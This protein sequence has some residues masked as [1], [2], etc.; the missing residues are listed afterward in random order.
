MKSRILA[1]TVL[2][3][4]FVPV[5]SVMAGS[6]GEAATSEKPVVT[7]HSW[8]VSGRESDVS[9][10][11]FQELEKRLDIEIDLVAMINTDN[12]NKLSTMLA[13]NELYDSMSMTRAF[14]AQYGPQGAFVD[15]TTTFD[16]APNL[17]RHFS[18]EADPWIYTRKELYF[19]PGSPMPYLAWGWAWNK[20][21]AD[22]LGI[23]PPKTMD[24]WLAAW[25]KVKAAKP[26]MVP[27][28]GRMGQVLGMLRPIFGTGGGMSSTP[29]LVKDGKMISPWI[30][31]NH[32]AMVTFMNTAYEERLVY[33]D[34]NTATGNDVQALFTTGQAF[35]VL[36]YSSRPFGGT[37]NE[38]YAAIDAPTGPFGDSGQMWIGLSSYWGNSIGNT[39]IENGVVDKVAGIWDFYFS[40]EGQE[41]SHFGKEGETFIKNADGTYEYTDFIREKAEAES[42]GNIQLQLMKQPYNILFNG[43]PAWGVRESILGGIALGSSQEQLRSMYYVGSRLGPVT[44]PYW[45][46]DEEADRLAE[47][48]ADIST[49]RDEWQVKF[50]VGQEPLSTWDTYVAGMKKL[51]IDEVLEIVNKGYERYLEVAGKPKGFVPQADAQISTKGL[52]KYVG[53]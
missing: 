37:G 31:D 16:K 11:W 4:F 36:E 52:E 2:L 32:K 48:E 20:E 22:E 39:A 7:Y 1:I 5:I 9:S 10:L 29:Y 24:D 47:L 44:P 21:V 3:M 25:R 13:S 35:T 40:P 14:A 15:V 23:A 49:Y 42:D 18:I 53:L 46:T 34:F 26:D 27:V 45:L 30:T 19:L 17:K 28:A 33:Q 12:V 8:F 43:G 50:I 38:A 41:L 6:Q 51:G